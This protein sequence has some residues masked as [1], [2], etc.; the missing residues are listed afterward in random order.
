MYV[1]SEYDRQDSRARQRI[2][3]GSGKLEAARRQVGG[4]KKKGQ[5]KWSAL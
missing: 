5:M 3:V 1:P 4:Q 2:A